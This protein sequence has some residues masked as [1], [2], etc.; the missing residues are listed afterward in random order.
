VFEAVESDANFHVDVVFDEGKVRA[1]LSRA[2][3]G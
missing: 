2:A 1:M 3:G